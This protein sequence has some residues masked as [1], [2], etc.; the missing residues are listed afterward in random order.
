MKILVTGCAGFIGSHLCEK[1]LARGD[2]VV[3]VDNFDSF[4]SRNVK[5]ANLEQCITNPKFTFAE[6]DLSDQAAV[7]TWWR[8]EKTSRRFDAVMHLAAKAGVRPSIADPIGYQRANTLATNHLLDCLA[9][10]DNH[11][12][13]F[14]FASSSS[15]YGNNPK[16]PFSES[17]CVDYP[18]SPYAQTKK[19]C[20]LLCHTYHHLH[21]IDTFC[22]RFFTVYGP[23]QRPDLAIH[24]FTAR[25][26]AGSAI[27]MYGTGDSSRDYT[28]IGDIVDG[29]VKAI[30]RC[31]GYEVIN[32]GSKHPVTLSKMIE[33]VEKACG[34]KAAILKRPMQLGDVNRTFADVSKAAQLLDYHP[35]TAFADGIREFV[36]WYKRSVR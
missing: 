24:K 14:V 18:I 36:A 12:A 31:R 32:L 26:L 1:L 19:A 16:V 6:L 7:N 17:D 25:I 5:E 9:S 33:T 10:D 8:A 4:Y 21:E 23:R 30:D 15:V 35:T 11:R 2:E 28:Y 3:G 29:V 22:L 27:E 20:E 13:K 34:V